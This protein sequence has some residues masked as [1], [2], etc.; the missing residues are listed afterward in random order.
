V[1]GF[2]FEITARPIDDVLV[3]WDGGYNNFRSSVTTPGQPGYIAP[4]NLIQPRWNM[5]GGVQYTYRFT[6]GAVSPRVDWSYQTAQTFEPSTTT[7]PTAEYTLPSRSIFNAL[8]TYVPSD[9]KWQ[10]NV[11][12]TNLTNKFYYYQLFTGAAIDIS[13]NVAP[14]RE[15]TVQV[16][17]NF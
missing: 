9:S 17:R 1:E 7:R 2:E 8:V 15:Y 12:I 14:P 10:V 5:A 6:A 16:R 11:G 4:G 3:N 13:S